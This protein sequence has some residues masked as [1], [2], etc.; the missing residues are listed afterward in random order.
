MSVLPVST[1]MEISSKEQ[2]LH[3]VSSRSVKG[4]PAK[5]QICS[6]VSGLEVMISF[7]TTSFQ[8]KHIQKLIPLSF[9]AN[10][11]FCMV[12]LKKNSS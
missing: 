3:L 8:G 6:S 5:H 12:L 1:D 10:S 4:S 9:H 11:F 2:I 7:V